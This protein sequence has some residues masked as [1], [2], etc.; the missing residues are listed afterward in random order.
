MSQRCVLK[1]DAASFSKT[2]VSTN[3]NTQLQNL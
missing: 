3:K 2:L 1:T